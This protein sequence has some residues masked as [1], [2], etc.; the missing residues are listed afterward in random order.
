MKAI[1]QHS[2]ASFLWFSNDIK[3]LWETIWFMSSDPTWQLRSHHFNNIRQPRK[4]ELFIVGFNFKMWLMLLYTLFRTITEEAW[5]VE[6]KPWDSELGCHITRPWVKDVRNDTIWLHLVDKVYELGLE[7]EK[8]L[9]NLGHLHRC[10]STKIL[11]SRRETDLLRIWTKRSLRFIH[12]DLKRIFRLKI[13]VI[14]KLITKVFSKV[15]M[16]TVR[17]DNEIYAIIH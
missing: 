13:I 5:T 15:K 16:W 1:H 7:H 3:Q 4:F 6:G 17:N 8:R 9:E 14:D 10:G 12:D 2:I 11:N